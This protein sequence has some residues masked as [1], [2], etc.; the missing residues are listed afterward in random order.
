MGETVTAVSVVVKRQAL[1]PAET[2]VSGYANRL[3]RMWNP[4]VAT[5]YLKHRITEMVDEGGHGSVARIAKKVGVTPQTISNMKSGR[6][7]SV[8]T[9][10]AIAHHLWGKSHDELFAEALEWW[11]KQYGELPPARESRV[12]YDRP[13]APVVASMEGFDEALVEARRRYKLIPDYA[14]DEVG[15]L[16]GFRIRPPITADLLLDLALVIAKHGEPAPD[17]ED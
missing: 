15:N 12:E 13:R 10:D 3:R 7:V 4:R 2:T 8:E 16:T 6:G 11:R 14:W 9:F 17:D 1:S 5:A